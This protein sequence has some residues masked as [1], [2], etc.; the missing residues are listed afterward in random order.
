MGCSSE[1]GWYA[2]GAG[3]VGG[4]RSIA[5]GRNRAGWKMF[6]QSCCGATDGRIE[7]VTESKLARVDGHVEAQP[8]HRV[9][10]ANPGVVVS[11]AE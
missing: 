2:P 5:A 9:G 8:V 7:R 11:E 6:G 1:V 4:F 3:A 10:V